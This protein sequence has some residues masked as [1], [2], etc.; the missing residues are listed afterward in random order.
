MLWSGSRALWCHPCAL[1]QR[2]TARRGGGCSFWLLPSNP[3][4]AVPIDASGPP[5]YP[6]QSVAA[7]EFPQGR[8]A[9]G[10]AA[11]CALANHPPFPVPQPAPL[12]GPLPPAV[13]A[14]A[15]RAAGSHHR[16]LRRQKNRAMGPPRP[17]GG[18][19]PVLRPCSR[20]MGPVPGSM[21]PSPASFGRALA[22]VMLHV[23]NTAHPRPA[24]RIHPQKHLIE[25]ADKSSSAVR[26]R[27]E[28]SRGSGPSSTT[29]FRQ[30]WSNAARLARHHAA[31]VITQLMDDL[32]ARPR[33]RAGGR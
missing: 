19:A 13:A 24:S 26:A 20:R 33:S 28:R 9:A 10:S 17:S 14:S 27:S 6:G 8:F 5:A 2:W 30:L 23:Q 32:L 1:V 18:H 4:A 25:G 3:E 16:P 15:A 31:R 7:A 11:A 21:A 22:G 12:M 29:N